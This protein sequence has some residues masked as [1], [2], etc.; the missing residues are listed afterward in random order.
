MV[1]EL[2]SP[3]SHLNK[4]HKLT[5]THCTYVQCVLSHTGF[6]AQGYYCKSHLTPYRYT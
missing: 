6:I 4:L 2:Q 3:Y 5:N 1:H